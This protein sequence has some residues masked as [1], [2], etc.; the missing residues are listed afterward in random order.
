M[1]PFPR[2]KLLAFLYYLGHHI[3]ISYQNL[4]RHINDKDENHKNISL[5]LTILTSLCHAN[6][7]I[8]MFVLSLISYD[9]RKALIAKHNED[10]VL[11]VIFQL[12]AE[13][14]KISSPNNINTPVHS[15]ALILCY[16]T[17]G[18]VTKIQLL[19][20]TS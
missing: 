4:F 2:N 17:E 15:I 8:T 10:P 13:H 20:I 12:I 3:L 16:F 5:S 19:L 6:Y 14:A 11:Q 7:S 9:E 1:R 18:L